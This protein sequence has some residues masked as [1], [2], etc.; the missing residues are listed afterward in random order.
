MTNETVAAPTTE[1]ATP[2]MLVS[3][4]WSSTAMIDPGEAGAR[5]PELKVTLIAIPVMPPR[6]AAMTIIGFM[7]TYGK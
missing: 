4:A 2:G 5:S 6:I 3:G 1:R 7:S